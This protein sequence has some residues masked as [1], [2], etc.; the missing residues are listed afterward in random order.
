M[1]KSNACAAMTSATKGSAIV[2]ETPNATSPRASACR[3]DTVNLLVRA[4]AGRRRQADCSLLA[5]P[6][7]RGGR[8]G[9]PPLRAPLPLPLRARPELI[10]SSLR[11]YPY[12]AGA[13]ATPQP[14]KRTRGQL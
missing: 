11:H 1:R 3:S 10:G 7:S 6:L 12:G 13:P 14:H 4:Q 2:R 8:G 9:P 5:A